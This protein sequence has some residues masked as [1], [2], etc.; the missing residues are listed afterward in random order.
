M[1][2]KRPAIQLWLKLL[3]LW[4]QLVAFKCEPEGHFE[5]T[6]PKYMPCTGVQNQGAYFIHFSIRHLIY[7]FILFYVW[8]NFGSPYSAH[9]YTLFHNSLDFE[10][11]KNMKIRTL[12]RTKTM[13]RHNIGPSCIAAGT[14]WKN[15]NA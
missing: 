8:F 3:V 11:C 7:L 15:S 6:Y 5:V 12:G 1:E 4:S 10:N 9:V 2:G 14:Y 13:L